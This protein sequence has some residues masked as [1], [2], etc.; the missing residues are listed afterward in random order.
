MAVDAVQDNNQNFSP[1]FARGTLGTADVKGT[2]GVVAGA[3]DPLTGAQY[4]YNLAP[5]GSLEIGS[6]TVGNI[7]EVGTVTEITNGTIRVTDGTVKVITPGTITSGSIAVTDGTVKV[8]TP[9]TITSGT[10]SIN[11]GT[12]GAG[13]LNTLGT[14]SNILAGT[15][16]NSGTVTGV[17]VVSQVTTGSIV[18]TAGTVESNVTIGDITGGT[19]DEITNG[20]IR[21]TAGTVSQAGAWNVTGTINSGSVAVTAGTVA[22]KDAHAAGTTANPLFVAGNNNGTVRGFTVNNSGN[23]QADLVSGT[24]NLGTVVPSGGTVG[25]VPGVGVVTTVTNLANGTIQNSG[26]TTGVGTISNIAV[27]HNA[28]TVAALPDLPG[29]TVD[30]VSAITTGSIVVTAGTVETTVG[31]LTGGTIDLLTTGSISNLAMLHA[32]TVTQLGTVQNI[33]VIH[34]AGTLAGGTIA[35]AGVVTTVS[36]LTNGTVRV[37]AGTINTGTINLGTVVGNVDAGQATASFPVYVGGNNNGTVRAFALN[38]SGEGSVIVGTVPGIGVV[39]TLS[40]L[41]NGSVRVTAGTV[42]QS[43]AWSVTGTVNSGTIDSVTAVANLT[44]GTVRVTAGTVNSGTINAGTINSGTINAGTVTKQPYPASQVLSAF[45]IGTAAAGTLVSAGGAGVG[46][47]PNSVI[48]TAMSGT[49]DMCLS[50]ALGSTSN[51]VVQRGLYAPGQGVAISFDNPS[52][53]GT[54]NSALTYQILSGAGT[55]SWAVTYNTKGT[56]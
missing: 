12:I 15:I 28:G 4:V 6:I 22:G 51:Q 20:T 48:L 18:V 50:F 8:V 46:I 47:Y 1:V 41:T 13:T 32:G 2:S 43:G 39:T 29:G 45:A 31:D 27:V 14:V 38:A 24:L 7:A 30:V 42:A 54:A 26:T 11:A 10:V 44:N 25:T 56:P 9:G 5:A 36:N 34:N 55:A 17:G 52:F 53:Y 35:G 19:I 40:N 37:T 23:I 16:Q 49:L 21:V 33:G 3:A